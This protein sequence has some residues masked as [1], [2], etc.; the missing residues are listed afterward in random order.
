MSPLEPSSTLMGLTKALPAF[1]FSFSRTPNS[2]RMELAS[3]DSLSITSVS[4]YLPGSTK[5]SPLLD[6]LSLTDPTT[7]TLSYNRQA[8][9]NSWLDIIKYS[10][11]IPFRD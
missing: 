11:W 1:K 3:A 5:L 8:I 9:K 4:R 10:Q 7:S 2:L 6:E